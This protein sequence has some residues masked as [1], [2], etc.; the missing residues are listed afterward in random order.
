MQKPK[1]T[2]LLVQIQISSNEIRHTSSYVDVCHV[3]EQILYAWDRMI[4]HNIL[5]R[6]ELTEKLVQSFCKIAEY[7]VDRVMAQLATDGF[8]GQLQPFLPPA[9]INI[10]RV[11]AVVFGLLMALVLLRHQQLRASASKP[12]H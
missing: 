10:V 6:T 8:C 11:Y 5:L 9:L 4:I 7:Y 12:V 2:V 1:C 3:I